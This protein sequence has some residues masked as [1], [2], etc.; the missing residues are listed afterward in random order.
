[1]SRK[2]DG[3]GECPHDCVGGHLTSCE[4]SEPAWDI[5]DLLCRPPCPGCCPECRPSEMKR[6]EAAVAARARRVLGDGRKRC[7]K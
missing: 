3:G 7:R 6:E 2:K 4:C 1:M 5:G